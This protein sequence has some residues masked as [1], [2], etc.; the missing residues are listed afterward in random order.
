M[1]SLQ[2]FITH[3]YPPSI[4][5]SRRSLCTANSC[6]NGGTCLD[7]WISTSCKCANGF[8]G[9]SCEEQV[10]VSFTTTIMGMKLES[11][12]SIFNLTLKFLVSSPQD[13]LILSTDNQISIFIS[14]GGVYIGFYNPEYR[15]ITQKNRC[16]QYSKW[17]MA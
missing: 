13:G 3:Q 2:P 11:L 16:Q 5:C 9:A 17:R 14:R 12:S 4:G 10:T 7:N 6:L 15:I 8:Q 1:T